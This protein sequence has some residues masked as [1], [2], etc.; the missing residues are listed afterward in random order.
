M[1]RLSPDLEAVLVIGPNWIGDA[2]MSTPALANLRRGLPK[3]TIDLLVP[4]SRGAVVRRPP[5]YRS[6]GGPR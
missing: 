6:G 4:A 2:V 5:P 3:A 1:Q